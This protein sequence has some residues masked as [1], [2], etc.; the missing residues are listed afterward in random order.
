M[1]RQTRVQIFIGSHYR[2]GVRNN[3][4]K[5]ANDGSANNNPFAKRPCHSH[6]FHVHDTGMAIGSFVLGLLV[7]GVGFRALYVICAVFILGGM[8]VYLIIQSR[9]RKQKSAFSFREG[10]GLADF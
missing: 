8:G 5:Y 7:S 10:F 4:S 2:I 9:Q 3:H 6:F 1:K